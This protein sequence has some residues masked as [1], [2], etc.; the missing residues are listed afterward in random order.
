MGK[1]NWFKRTSRRRLENLHKLTY[2]ESF[3]LSLFS[4]TISK[5]GATLYHIV[6][7]K[8]TASIL[9]NAQHYK[10]SSYFSLFPKLKREQFNYIIEKLDRLGLIKKAEVKEEYYLT[11]EGWLY[12]Q[13]Y[14][15]DHT[16]P[17]HLNLLSNGTAL[18]QFWRIILLIT[19]VLSESR[20]HNS[21]YLPIEKEWEK[22][23]WLKK[24]LKQQ[25]KNK[26]ELA[27]QFGKEWIL[28]LKQLPS[29]NAELIVD[30]LSGHHKIGKTRQQLADSYQLDSFEIEL[31]LL[32]SLSWIWKVIEEQQQEVPLFHSI[33]QAINKE[34]RGITQSAIVTESYL[35]EG[36][37][38]EETAK[39]R[40][41]K[42]S[43]VSEHTIE[44][45]IVE[46][47]F[48]LSL[49]LSEKDFNTVKQLLE[50]QPTI[51]YHEVV[52]K[53]PEILFLWYRLAQIER[54]H[55]NE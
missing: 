44:L 28:L 36:H 39:L 18:K 26:Q 49:V 17:V 51:A 27:E 48:D 54:N 43:T 41:L 9:Y 1:S 19:Q 50:E 53:R 2:L 42:F 47:A 38:L 13:Q 29:L 3:C 34:Y 30:C 46:P 16:Y 40:Q 37:S 25:S 15:S 23:M 24:W 31:L 4:R 6:T 22:Q 33:Y 12:C 52:E 7:G 14:F 35:L 10:L 32:D 55:R 21:H 5:K 20:Y 11:E 45:Y 8:R